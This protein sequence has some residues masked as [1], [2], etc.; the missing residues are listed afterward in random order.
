MNDCHI[1]TSL[2]RELFERYRNDS[3]TL[4]VEELGLCHGEVRIDLA[5]INGSFHG[6]ELKSDRDTLSR[7]PTQANEYS[8]VFDKITLVTGCKHAYE[9]IKLIP[10][11]WG[12]RIVEQ[13]LVGKMRFHN[14]RREKMN[15]SADAVAITKLLWREEAISFLDEIDSADGVRS[16]T[17]REIYKKIIE[18]ADLKTIRM[19]I[20]QQL[21][22]RRNWRFAGQQKLDDD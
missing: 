19:K 11:W 4:I 6:Y 10:E 13:D 9:A 14:I 15:P 17:K 22:M 12:V 1:R 21:R 2:K 5:V 18:K 20:R 16:K 7:L 8:R 3:D